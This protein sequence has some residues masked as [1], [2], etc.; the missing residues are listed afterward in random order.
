MHPVILLILCH[1]FSVT[2]AL[3]LY[4]TK[5]SRT[6]LVSW[7]LYE[8][9]VAF[10]LGDPR[11]LENPHPFKQMPAIRDGNI[12]IFESGAILAYLAEKYGSIDSIEKRSQFLKWI[13]WGANSHY[14]P[15]LLYTNPTPLI[16]YSELNT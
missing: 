3:V 1:V 11:S 7:Y 15:N 9:N 8:L 16:T 4:G 6:P 12:E 2:F 14:S 5:G 13:I 10:K